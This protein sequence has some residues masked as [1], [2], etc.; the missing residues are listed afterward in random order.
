MVYCRVLISYISCYKIDWIVF[1]KINFKLLCIY[2][3]E[4]EFLLN[5]ISFKEIVFKINFWK[6]GLVF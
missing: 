3:N 2:N 4:G 1:F 6:V 5:L